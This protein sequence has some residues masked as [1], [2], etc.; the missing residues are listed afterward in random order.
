MLAVQF[1]F[2]TDTGIGK[3]LDV[4]GLGA[5]ERVVIV[6]VFADDR[7]DDVDR[8]NAVAGSNALDRAHQ[9]PVA[10]ED[11]NH[12]VELRIVG[13]FRGGG[14]AG[15]GIGNTRL[16]PQPVSFR[17]DADR[18]GLYGSGIHQNKC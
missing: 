6:G 4:I 9:L 10:L 17:H 14:S 15:R 18:L 7:A 13:R 5:V 3:R 1:E 12:L 8:V 11:G 16:R 2:E